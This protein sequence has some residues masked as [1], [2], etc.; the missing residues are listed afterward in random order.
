M[1]ATCGW[2]HKITTFCN[3]QY[4]LPLEI[5]LDSTLSLILNYKTMFESVCNHLYKSKT[6]SC[7]YFFIVSMYISL[8]GMYFE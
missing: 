3:S 7:N 1:Y 2:P 6:H 5:L 8:D 4:L